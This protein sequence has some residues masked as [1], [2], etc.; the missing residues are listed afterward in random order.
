[1]ISFPFRRIAALLLAAV[2]GAAIGGDAGFASE[3]AQLEAA[4]RAQPPA[5]GGIVFVGS[6]SIRL[7]PDLRAD[8]PGA[9]VL[10][11]G[12]GGATLPDV[13]YYAPRIVLPARPRLIV[14]YAGDNDLAAGRTPEQV[15]ADYAAF[16][17]LV[18][19]ALPETRLVYI[20]IK[21]SPSRWALAG[22]MQRANALIAAQVARDSLAAF[23]DV[24]ARMLGAD[25]RPQPAL[26]RADSLHMTPAGYALWRARLAPLVH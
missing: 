9:P 16:V 10:N 23:V 21:P 25:G 26:Y 3:I 19:R 12:F 15:A 14:L 22:A 4:D 18:R 5:P 24:F 8:F 20:A 7:W 6:S 17:A 13:V 11:R 1:M 2:G